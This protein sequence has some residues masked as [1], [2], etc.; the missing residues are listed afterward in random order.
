MQ[1]EAT[2]PSEDLKSTLKEKL[3]PVVSKSECACDCVSDQVRK[4][5]I[6]FLIGSAVFGA[7]V[8]YLILEGK[9]QPTTTEKYLSGP[10]SDACSSLRSGTRNAY[11]TIKFW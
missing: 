6:S 4:N 3:S 9:S 1:T 11:E 2:P 8:C 7:A 10:L 5:P